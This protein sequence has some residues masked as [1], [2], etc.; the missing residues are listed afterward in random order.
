MVSL[1]NIQVITGYSNIMVEKFRQLPITWNKY[2]PLNLFY[3]FFT[4]LTK[5]FVPS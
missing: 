3:L 1:K 5:I 2:F 4:E